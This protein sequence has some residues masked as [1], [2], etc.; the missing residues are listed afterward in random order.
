[1]EPYVKEGE[2]VLT[3]RY[4]FSKP[5]V[6]EVI[7]F[8]HSTPPHVF[9]KRISWIE[10]NKVWVVG[11]NK[12]ESVDSRTFGFINRENIIGKVITVI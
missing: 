11:D 4:M 2:R 3:L 5:K 6:G 10:K 9:I 8:H 12:K 7:I 1:M